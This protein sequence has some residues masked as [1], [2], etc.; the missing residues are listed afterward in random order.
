MYLARYYMN[1]NKWISALKRLN[2][3]LSEYE[4]TYLFNRSIT[5]NGRNLL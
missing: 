3:V 4:T 1:K 2:I 5:S